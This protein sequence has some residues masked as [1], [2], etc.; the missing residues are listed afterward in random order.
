MGEVIIEA[1][2]YSV[3]SI[4]LLSTTVVF[5][6]YLTFPDLRT[7][8]YRIVTYLAL[9][10]FIWELFV[11]VCKLDDRASACPIYAYLITSFQL[12]SMIWTVY[13]AYF[14]KNS[15]VN[16]TPQQSR[17]KWWLSP[18]LGFGVPLGLAAL[19]FFTNSY[20]EDNLTWCWIAKHDSLL[21]NIWF[22]VL[23]FF[24]LAIGLV[25]C[26]IA[27]VK[28][29]KV[30]RSDL[31]ILELDNDE[32]R[33]RLYFIRKLK[34]FPMILMICWVP[35]FILD[36]V[37]FII[38]E[39]SVYMDQASAIFSCTQGLM[40]SLAYSY[41]SVLANYIRNRF[42]PRFESGSHIKED[43]IDDLLGL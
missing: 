19:P 31:E 38:G 27:Y 22:L 1:S 41:S 3:I 2:L 25:Y 39:E 17:Y 26:A 10:D 8:L 28:A 36:F 7:P 21:V 18:L 37:L 4:S 20:T 33:S 35:G 24:P 30:L 43:L 40:N 32:L 6:S 11:L 14:I 16:Q 9:S 29:T 34:V 42:C 5:A 12:A 23:F 13:I 15:V